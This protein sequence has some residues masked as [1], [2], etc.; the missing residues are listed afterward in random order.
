MRLVLITHR[1]PKLSETFI[2]G[3]FAGLS[4]IGWDVHVVCREV[5]FG[6]WN[7]FPAL[8]DRPDLKRRV[9]R[10]WPEQ[11]GLLVLV[12]W[13]P[14]LLITFLRAPQATWRYWTR[15]PSRFGRQ[16]AK[17]F[18]LDAAII[19]LDPEIVHYE[20]GAMAAGKTYLRQR[21]DCRL[22]VSFRG[23]DLHYAG[24][25]NPEYYRNLW[26]EADAIHLLGSSLWHAAQNRGCPPDMRHALI[27]PAVDTKRVYRRDRAHL[28]R[29]IDPERPL[30]VLSVGRLEWVK[31]YEYALQAVH[32]LAEQGC[33]FQYRIIGDGAY[34]EPLAFARYQLSLEDRVDFLGSLPQE[35]V[36]EEMNRA[37]V[38]LQASVSEGFGNAALEA[39]AM[40][41]PIVTTDAGGLPENV[42]DGRTGFVVPRRDPEAL[43]RKLVELARDGELRMRL[44]TAGR[45]RVEDCF[46]MPVQIAAFDR[47]YREMV[48]GDEN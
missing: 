30:R 35:A 19:A 13:L 27:P 33:P 41:L 47:F 18:Y 21:L 25:A 7:N 34:L 6:G 17:Q 4:D 40:E 5:G 29:A 11:P 42:A 44:G 32:F 20:F 37:D 8:A 16:T 46:T 39:Q 2:A 1:F 31:G 10:H 12:L 45:H 3:K 15:S 48:A 43:C 22:S 24:L 14:L 26:K 36:F 23:Y 9:H 28:G 38:F